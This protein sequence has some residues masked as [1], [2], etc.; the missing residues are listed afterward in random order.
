MININNIDIN[1]GWYR[2][3]IK[4]IIT[5]DKNELFLCK[6]ITWEWC[7]PWGWIDYWEEVEN[8]IIREIKEEMWLE[9]TNID[10]APIFFTTLYKESSK[11][12]PWKAVLCYKIKVKNLDFTPSNECLEIWFFNKENILEVNTIPYMPEIINKL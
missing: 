4:C 1:D 2:L 6:K 10:S 8:C 12:R 3:S 7:L 11:H 9:V 5:N